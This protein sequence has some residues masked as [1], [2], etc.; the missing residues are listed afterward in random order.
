LSPL[1]RTASL[2]ND[3]SENVNSR[4]IRQPAD[5]IVV[6][7]YQSIE[8]DPVAVMI[9]LGEASA[10]VWD[11]QLGHLIPFK[12]VDNLPESYLLKNFFIKVNV[13]K[14]LKINMLPN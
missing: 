9:I 10:P 5:I 12:R 4:H 3:V 6:V 13:V 1:F 8:P 14:F 2:K 11:G 7:S